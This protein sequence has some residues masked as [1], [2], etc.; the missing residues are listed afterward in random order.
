MHHNN[1]FLTIIPARKG[2][3]RIPGKNLEKIGGKPM[4][5]FTIEA[6]ISA[7]PAQNIIISTDD[8]DVINLSKKLGIDV[9]F[10]RPNNLSTDS[11][12]TSDVIQHLLDWYQSKY[13]KLP[14]NIL[15]LQPTSPFR[16]ANDIESAIDKFS[17][18][19]KKTLVSVSDPIQHPGDF[20]LK[21][22]DGKFKRLEVGKDACR[23]QSY[24]EVFFIDG[25]I[26]ISETNHFLET[27][28]LIG[29]DPEIFST[30]QFNSIDI[31]TPFDLEWARAMHSYRLTHE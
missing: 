21:G 6:A 12:K 11:A 9:P 5:Q 20:I 29:D 23:G 30:E 1:S 18:S 14:E 22:Q 26:Y 25:G 16:N 13:K 28:D 4:I 10:I 7:I 17:Q 8:Y 15:L 2:S 24:P 19:N 31:D 3:K 27:Q